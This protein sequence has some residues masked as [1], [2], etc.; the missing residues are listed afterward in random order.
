[1]I[2]SDTNPDPEF[3][4]AKGGITSNDV[5]V[6]ALGVKRATVLG[7][8]VPGVPVW[9]C[10]EETLRPGKFLYIYMTLTA[11]ASAHA[12]SPSGYRPCMY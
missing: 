7:Q 10:G 2:E 4:I 6:E 9:R 3:L 1:M 5:A 11:A 8:V 12:I